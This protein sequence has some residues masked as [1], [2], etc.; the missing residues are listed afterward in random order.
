MGMVIQNCQKKNQMTQ[1]EIIMY[2]DHV[3]AL[4][5]YCMLKFNSFDIVG[6]SFS[7]GPEFQ[8]TLVQENNGTLLQKH[9][10]YVIHMHVFACRAVFFQTLAKASTF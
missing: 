9:A 3:T 2:L 5:M 10:K 6:P 1:L 7:F 4:P 8:R